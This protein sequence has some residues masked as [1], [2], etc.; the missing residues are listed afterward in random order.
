MLLRFLAVLIFSTVIVASA[1]DEHL[2]LLRK[3]VL[4]GNAE[5]V[6][7]ELAKGTDPNTRLT[8]NKETAL[9][10]AAKEGHVEIIGILL[11]AN[12]NQAL[13]NGHERTPLQVALRTNRT[14]CFAA[15][16]AKSNLKET[17]KIE[18]W[19]EA[20]CQEHSDITN[21]M[22]R[23]GIDK[24]IADPRGITALHLAAYYQSVA[25]L[26]ALVEAGASVNAVTKTG[27]TPLHYAA[28]TRKNGE[29]IKLLI[30]AGT[31]PNKSDKNGNY[32]MNRAGRCPENFKVLHAAGAKVRTA[33]GLGRM[34]SPLHNAVLLGHYEFVKFLLK[35]KKLDV[36]LR[37][38]VGGT[39]P[40][41]L[42][43]S[44]KMAK[45]LLGCGADPKAVAKDG[46]TVLH[47]AVWNKLSVEVITHLLEKGADPGAA[48]KK[49]QTPFHEAV[50][51]GRPDVM[52]LLLKHSP[53]LE[54]NSKGWMGRTPLHMAAHLGNLDAVKI[55]F[56]HRPKLD[57]NTK[58]AS[59][60]SALILATH[61]DHHKIA[62]YLLEKGADPNVTDVFTL[63]PL[64]HAVSSKK[65]AAT[66]LQLVKALLKSKAKR[67]AKDEDGRTPLD[68]ARLAKFKEAITL[69]SEEN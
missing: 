32:P 9:H 7:K 2:A 13:L 10:L 24:D 3:A 35:E 15:L 27:A 46:N 39:C 42:A 4:A 66:R 55:L 61:R 19:H 29:I 16:W 14:K 11:N 60:K 34:D 31:D 21:L 8:F 44:D 53:N 67:D 69:L 54:I 48:T 1:K 45:L 41:H 6:K 49:G 26:K 52:Q 36:N 68:F 40:V 59:G 22:L 25:V 51:R 33:A 47:S 38:T 57:A 28:S 30:K 58:D 62:L 12:A 65:D 43:K 23:L 17:Q 18:L 56:Q 37:T 50:F 63:T 5:A 64:H 20:A